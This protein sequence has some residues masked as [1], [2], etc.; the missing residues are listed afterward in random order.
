MTWSCDAHTCAVCREGVH[1]KQLALSCDLASTTSSLPRW[2]NVV[3]AEGRRQLSAP[4]D[5]KAPSVRGYRAGRVDATHIADGATLLGLLQR[6]RGKGYRDAL[7]GP[8]PVVSTALLECITRDPRTDH[9][10]ESRDEYYGR[11]ALAVD[12][13]SGGIESFLFASPRGDDADPSDA[14][15]GL[16]T[17]AWMGRLGRR[18]AVAMLRRYVESGTH[19]E[20]A[21]GAM[22]YPT[23]IGLNGLDDAVASRSASLD[24][25]ARALPWHDAMPWSA[26]RKHNPRIAEA[27]ALRTEWHREQDERRSALQALSTQELLTRREVS[28]LRE[29]TTSADKQVLHDAARHGADQLRRDAIK[30]LGWQRDMSVFDAAEQELR[31]NPERDADEEWPPNAGA[32]AISQLLKFAPIARV[33]DWIGEKGRTGKVA[34]HMMAMWP[35][36]GDAP[37]LRATIERREDDEWLYPICDAVDGLATLAD[38]ESVPQLEHVFGATTYSYLRRRAARA[39]AVTSPSFAEGLAVECLWDCEHETR[40][41]GCA[42]ASW[43]APATRERLSELA[44]DPLQ[45]RRVRITAERRR[46]ALQV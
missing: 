29:R 10:V 38:R 39:L 6:G 15:L 3:A 4:F 17:L 8:R 46:R 31:R 45:D 2:I 33:R 5:D 28:L 32:I 12:L 44:G 14:E 22:G 26:W 13:D 41:M 42:A 27:Y 9:Q 36:P 43:T 34:L 40:M 7:T 23:P 35:M 1:I 21:V 37:L 20:S 30:V 11:C 25:L 19:W 24:E 16:G 18:D